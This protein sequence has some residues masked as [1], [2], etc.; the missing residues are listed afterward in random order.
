MLGYIIFSFVGSTFCVAV[1]ACSYANHRRLYPGK[2]HP[3]WLGYLRDMFCYAWGLWV[4]Y[5]AMLLGI[6]YALVFVF[7]TPVAVML[8][9]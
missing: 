1:L 8:A 9:I 5:A 4:I 7:Q 2:A 6:A 3:G